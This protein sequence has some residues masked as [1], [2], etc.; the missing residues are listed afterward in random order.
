MHRLGSMQP[1]GPSRFQLLPAAC[2]PRGSTPAASVLTRRAAA[3]TGPRMHASRSIGSG[4]PSSSL[5]LPKSIV[6][7][8]PAEDIIMGF[9]IRRHQMGREGRKES[10]ERHQQRR[11]PTGD[12]A[13]YRSARST[14]DA[15]DRRV[16]GGCHERLDAAHVLQRL[17]QHTALNQLLL[18]PPTQLRPLL[19]A[20]LLPCEL[21]RAPDCPA[22]SARL[23]DTSQH[24]VWSGEPAGSRL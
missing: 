9:R 6:S 22:P 8:T 24:I 14:E 21:R 15:R 20:H 13:C 4:P 10:S 12:G 7:S 16:A 1:V 17:C 5:S 2:S 11:T 19:D 18:D 23:P 3:T